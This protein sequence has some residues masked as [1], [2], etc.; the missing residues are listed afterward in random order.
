M[1]KFVTAVLAAIILLAA[2]ATAHAHGRTRL[3]GEV[4]V[5]IVSDRGSALVTIPHKDFWSNGTRTIKKYLEARR[6]ENYGIVIRNN[7]PERIGVVVAVDGRNI[8][9]GK[10]SDL[11]KH[12]G[13]VHRGGF[14]QYA[15]RRMENGQGHGAPVLLYRPR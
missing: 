9:S 5:E 12:R 1:R 15:I 3:Q 13:H 8:I 14:W 2:A 7:S 11:E 6:G 10:Q 4:S